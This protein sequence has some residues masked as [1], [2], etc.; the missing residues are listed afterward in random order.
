MNIYNNKNYYGIS[1]FNVDIIINRDKTYYS[2]I[3]I[4]KYRLMEKYYYFTIIS[5]LGKDIYL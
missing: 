4:G 5:I 3:D 2:F 1:I